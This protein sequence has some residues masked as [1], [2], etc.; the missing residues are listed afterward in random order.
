MSW[1]VAASL[2]RLRDQ[3][4]QAYPGRN[5]ASDGTI[6]DAAHQA[7][8]SDHNPNAQSVV[9]ALDLTHSPDT[10]FDA[11]A[12]ADALRAV[13]H[14]DVKYIISAR[15]ICGDWT[16][17][18][19][20]PY[21]GSDP[22][23]N[24]IHVSVGRGDDGKSTQPYDDRNDWNVKQRTA[25]AGGK[26]VNDVAG[27]VLAGEWG[28]G[29]DRRNRL[30]A[31]GYDYDTVQA[32][33]NARL[34]GG[35]TAP[36]KSNEVIADEVLAG[37]W[38]NG[39]DRRQ[40]LTTAGYDYDA[41]Q[42]VVNQ[43]LGESQ[44]QRLSDDQVAD[45]VIAGAWGNGDDRRA[46]LSA[47]GYSYDAVH[48]AV[49]SKLGVGQSDKKSDDQIANEVIAGL[50]S[51]GQERKDKLAAAGYDYGTVQALVNRKLGY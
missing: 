15:R 17:W 26:S 51:N 21:N 11:H 9:C 22:H 40:A 36:R 3:V 10:G 8:A 42:A 2:E 39:D 20:W 12:L 45:Q 28:N 47:A 38:G 43:R 44:P 33:V 35:G 29:E 48:A 1:R 24:H 25:P 7:V 18:A 13:R 5:K 31:A 49:N 34:G 23:N 19:W 16:G 14:P 46:R 50:W 41:V 30:A 27:E 6:G 4:N 37:A 32:A